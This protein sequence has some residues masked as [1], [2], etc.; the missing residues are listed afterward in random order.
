MYPSP[1][2]THLIGGLLGAFG[3]SDRWFVGAFEPV[4]DPSDRW[5]AWGIWTHLT[6]DLL[7]HLS[8]FMSPSDRWFAG[9]SEPI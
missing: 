5:F 6:G 4:Y 9:V 8:P 3:P 7:V 1:F 2:M